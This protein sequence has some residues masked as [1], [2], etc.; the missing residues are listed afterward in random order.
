LDT[1]RARAAAR[2]GIAICC[3][4]SPTAATNPRT[5]EPAVVA[6][7]NS[8]SQRRSRSSARRYAD[9]QLTRNIRAVMPATRWRS[10]TLCRH[11]HSR[12]RVL[13]PT[14]LTSTVTSTHNTPAPQCLRRSPARHSAERTAIEDHDTFQVSARVSS[15][16]RRFGWRAAPGLAGWS[17][18]RWAMAEEHWHQARLIPTS[19]INGQDEAERRRPRH[20]WLW[21]VP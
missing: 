3:A 10:I 5:S 17:G 13:E 7:V 15:V 9:R 11:P 2:Q 20:C 4:T 16:L 19:G 1:R 8:A 18:R 21:S 14:L 6:S 12:D